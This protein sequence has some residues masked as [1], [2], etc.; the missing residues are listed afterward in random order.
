MHIYNNDIKKEFFKHFNLL[1][2]REMVLKIFFYQIF[3]RGTAY[4]VGG[5]FRDFLQ[6][7]ESRD[8]D[9]I[10]DVTNDYL[11]DVITELKLP[12]K[13]NRH[14]GIK[15]SLSTIE[16]DIW[17]IENNWAFKN[18]LV[19]LNED[20]KLNSIAKGCFYNYDSLVINLNNFNFNTKYYKKFLETREL[21]ILQLNSV[22]KNLNPT[23]EANI[24]RAFFLKYNYGIEY[25]ENTIN[26]LLKMIKNLEVKF[27]GGAF[28]K[29]IETKA[30]YPK[31]EVLTKKMIEV[32]TIQLKNNYLPNNQFSLDI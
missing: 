26:Y 17:S 14:N 16:I 28:Q 22:Y 20:D 2:E 7:R 6:Y 12:H 5:Y 4:I 24:L 29:L 31:Y 1:L 18:K 10:V 27:E 25:S 8:I 30:K 9:I 32:Y 13:I 21:D 15:I 19:K 23:T 11:I 3:L